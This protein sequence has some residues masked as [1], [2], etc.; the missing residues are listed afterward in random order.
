VEN[1]GYAGMVKFGIDP[2]SSEFFD[3][4]T[5]DL[6]FKDA[7]DKSSRTKLSAAKLSELYCSLL[8]D[9]P[10]VLLEDP[11]A[12]DDWEAW[13]AFNKTCKI[14]L[15]GDDLLATNLDRI[16]IAEDK[17]ACNSLLLK[18][19]QIGTITEATEA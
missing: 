4:G 16:K 9:Y 3:S 2:A 8:E 11:F 17:N 12:Q 18:I 19:N 5:Y 1:C 7:E 13:T 6:G 15:V 10:I 14:E